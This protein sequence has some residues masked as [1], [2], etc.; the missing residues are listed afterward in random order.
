MKRLLLAGLFSLLAVSALAGRQRARISVI[1]LS[2][3]NDPSANSRTAVVGL[4]YSLDLLFL[5]EYPPTQLAVMIEVDEELV[6]VTHLEK[7]RQLTFRYTFSADD[8]INAIMRHGGVG[9]EFSEPPPVFNEFVR[10]KTRAE[11]LNSEA[12]VQFVFKVVQIEFNPKTGEPKAGKIIVSTTYKINLSC[13]SCV[14]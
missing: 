3:D 10:P 14:A 2:A 8:Y 11:A 6:A 4:P 5:G 13:P 1:Y 12:A 7:G 9:A